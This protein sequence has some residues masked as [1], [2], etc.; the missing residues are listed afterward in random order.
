MLAHAARNSERALWFEDVDGVWVFQ[1]QPG[2]AR[3]SE[4]VRSWGIQDL[5]LHYQLDDILALLETTLRMDGTDPSK[6]PMQLHKETG[7]LLGTFE[8]REA[9]LIDQLLGQLR[10]NCAKSTAPPRQKLE[11]YLTTLGAEQN[12]LDRHL[13]EV[14]DQKAMMSQEMAALTRQGDPGKAVQMSARLEALQVETQM[15]KE[16]LQRLQMQRMDLRIAT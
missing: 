10:A 11:E 12:E 2:R 3:S 9:Q 8:D 6:S 16:Q 4:K 7:T 14:L 13:R 1:T 5:L 15:L